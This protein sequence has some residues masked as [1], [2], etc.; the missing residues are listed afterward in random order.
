MNEDRENDIIEVVSNEGMNMETIEELLNR[1]DEAHQAL[2]RCWTKD[3]GTP[4]YAKKDFMTL[5][6]ELSRRF[7][8]AAHAMGH[9]G[10]LIRRDRYTGS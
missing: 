10:P 5:D 8:D 4:G 3:V 2:N 9:H 6:N 1:Y 7:G